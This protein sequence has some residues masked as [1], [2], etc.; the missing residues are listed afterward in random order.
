MRPQIIDLPGNSPRIFW[1]DKSIE[2]HD[3]SENFQQCKPVSEWVQLGSIN[4][5][6]SR[7]CTHT[8]S[9]DQI[10]FFSQIF[11]IHSRWDCSFPLQIFPSFWCPNIL[12]KTLLGKN[13]LHSCTFMHPSVI[14]MRY[15]CTDKQIYMLQEIGGETNSTTLPPCSYL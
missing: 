6:P 14:Q 10:F 2:D 15:P 12:I 7:F 9:I 5:D 3:M 1:E 8:F 11:T 13:P 4:Q